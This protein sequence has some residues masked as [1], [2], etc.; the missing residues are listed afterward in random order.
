[1]ITCNVKSVF[2]MLLKLFVH[3]SV[4]GD[5]DDKL[6]VLTLEK[7]HATHICVGEQAGVTSVER[8]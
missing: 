6:E 8:V 7:L 1:M 3:I 2:P 5:S 4:N